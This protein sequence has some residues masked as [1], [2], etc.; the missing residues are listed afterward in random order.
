MFD[1]SE[2]HK[3]FLKLE[4]LQEW[5]INDLRKSTIF[6]HANFLVCMGVFSYAEILGSFYRYK[7]KYKFG[8]TKKGLESRFNFVFN[9][10]V[11]KAYKKEFSKI[12]RLGI[13]PYDMF[14]CGMV[15]EYLVKTYKGKNNVKISFTVYG[16]PDEGHYNLNKMVANC[17]VE[18]VKVKPGIFHIKINNAKIVEDLNKAFKEFKERLNADR[19]NYRKFFITRAKEIN[20]E[21]LI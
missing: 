20:L 3:Y 17:G 12:K 7:S 5:M 2:Y 13:N 14:R 1:V 21:T 8:G 6:G 16:S 9:E 18:V 15:H 19:K 4:K 10:L 11:D